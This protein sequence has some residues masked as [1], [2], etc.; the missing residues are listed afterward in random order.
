[1]ENGYRKWQEYQEEA[2]ELEELNTKLSTALAE[3][4]DLVSKL[5]TKFE[6]IRSY[7]SDLD[8]DPNNDILSLMV[9][10]SDLSARIAILPYPIIMK[11]DRLE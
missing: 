7:A 10:I 8:G 9:N 4:K 1:M 5:D 11:E 6:Y 2:K 3:A